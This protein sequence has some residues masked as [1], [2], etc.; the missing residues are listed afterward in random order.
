MG[1]CH[2]KEKME[3]LSQKMNAFVQALDNSCIETEPGDSALDI[4]VK[5]EKVLREMEE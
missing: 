1:L 3:F 2:L 4:I 5:I